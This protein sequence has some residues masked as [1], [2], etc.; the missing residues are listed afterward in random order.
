MDINN[1]LRELSI[2]LPEVKLPA[3]LPLV[4]GVAVGDLIFMSGHT[5]TVNGNN[6]YV[7]ILGGEISI[8]QA[9]EAIRI[10]TLNCLSQLERIVG[11]L[12]RVKRIVKLTGFVA[13]NS[14]FTEQAT[15]VNAASNL[16]IDI[17]GEKGQ[18]ARS[19]I[20]V[21]VLPGGVPV[22]VELI[23]QIQ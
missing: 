23:V 6:A 15:V 13:S 14:G 10:S 8:E 19:A 18:H 1:R 11:D 7:G 16:L 12:N 20:G 2:T 4:P 21:T 22:E 9:Q 3:G 17:F 5:P